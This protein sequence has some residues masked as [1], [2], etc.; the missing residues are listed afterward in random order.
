MHILPMAQDVPVEAGGLRIPSLR[1]PFVVGFCSSPVGA[2]PKVASVLLQR[3]RWGGYLARWNIGRMNFIV[4][5]GLYALGDPDADSPVVV[6]ANYKMSFDIVRSCLPGRHCWILVLDTKGINVWCAAGKGT[7][8]TAEL[9]DRI[10]VSRLS[11]IVRHRCLIVPQLGAPGLA[12]FAV[13]KYADFRVCYGPL[14]ARDLSAFL[15]NGNQATPAMRTMNF[16]L[17]DRLVLVPVELMQA[18]RIGLPAMLFFVMASSFFKAPFQVAMTTHGIGAALS[19]FLGIVGGTVLTPLLLPW[20]PGRAFSLKG[21]VAGMIAASLGLVFFAARGAPSG[22]YD[23]LEILSWV[24][25][26]LS[27]SSWY[28]M[29]FTGAST[30]TSQSGVRKEMLRAIPVQFVCV[31]GGLG[32]WVTSIMLSS[33]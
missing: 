10:A 4:E 33:R 22:R 30:Y 23:R 18:L 16:P 13:K 27:F 20:L 17:T 26:T 2:I 8:G 29:A 21:L 7:F 32:L 3:D 1:Q 15:D 6:T 14:R 28:G 31:L 24:I 9:I 5:P 11:E 19:I 12:A 25:L